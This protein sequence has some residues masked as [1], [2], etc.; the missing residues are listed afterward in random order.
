MNFLYEVVWG[1]SLEF[2]CIAEDP[3]PE[4]GKQIL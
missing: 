4:K 2:P 3:E 1:Q